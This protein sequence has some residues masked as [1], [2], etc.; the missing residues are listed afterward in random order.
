[1]TERIERKYVCDGC[2]D[3][4]EDKR[5]VAAHYEIARTKPAETTP[6]HRLTRDYCETCAPRFSAAL[7][8]EAFK[9]KALI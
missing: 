5:F 6:T 8:E 4:S 9:R 1:M 7:K 2:G 3:E